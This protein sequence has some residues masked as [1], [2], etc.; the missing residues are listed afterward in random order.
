LAEDQRVKSQTRNYRIFEATVCSSKR[1][2]FL[3]S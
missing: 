3:N 1:V 2:V